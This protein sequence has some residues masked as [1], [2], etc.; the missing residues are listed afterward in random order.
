M[1]KQE[2]KDKVCLFNKKEECSGCGACY[3]I[4]PQKAI[5]M[6]QDEEGFLYPEIDKNKCI[7]C[8]K[9]LSVCAFKKASKNSKSKTPKLY[10]VKVKD[11]TERAKSQSGGLFMAL[12]NPILKNKGRIYGCILNENFEAVHIGTENVKDRDKM[13]KSKYVQSRIENTFKE[14]RED[15]DNK[16]EVIF[17]GT[18]CQVDGLKKYLGKDYDNLYLIDIICHGVPSPMVWKDYIKW[19]EN[20]NKG[21][22]QNV[23]FRNKE[24]FG[25]HSHMETYKIKNIHNEIKEIDSSLYTNLFYSHLIL[26]P[27]CF[28]CPYKTIYRSSDITIGDYW[29]IEKIDKDFDDNKGVSIAII[30]TKKGEKL[31][32][33]IKN[34]INFESTTIENS[35]QEPLVKSYKKPRNRDKFWKDYKNKSLNRILNKY[36]KHGLKWKFINFLRKVKHK[37]HKMLSSKT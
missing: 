6:K 34:D 33:E 16:K 27:S 25:W 5:T 13:R 7:K 26:R 10:A 12:T 22:C 29:G 18:P 2:I 4:C 8:K 20:K 24:K 36:A 17:S 28:C 32:S 14:V 15:L 9:C 21:K 23:I 1:E 31:F 11:N 37:V 35:L 19:L 3:S 30:N